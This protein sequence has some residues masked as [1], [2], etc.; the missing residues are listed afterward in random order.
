[1]ASHEIDALIIG[2]DQLATCRGK[3]YGKPGSHAR[4][5]EQLQ[6][7]SGEAL[8][9]HTG[10]CLLNTTTSA[11]QLDCVEYRVQF[12]RYSTAEIER[13]LLA[14]RPYDCAGS[15]KSEQLGISLIDSM[16]GSDPSALIGLPLVRLA[17]MLRMEGLNIP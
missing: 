16:T 13:Y 7:M 12:R 10:L 5:T 8:I 6:Q 11:E 2:S 17:A 4:A 1:M 9:F 14:E 15:F 3:V